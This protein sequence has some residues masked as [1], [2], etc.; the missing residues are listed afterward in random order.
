MNKKPAKK[1][2][3]ILILVYLLILT[4]N[5]FLGT[6]RI[7]KAHEHHF[8][9]GACAYGFLADCESCSTQKCNSYWGFDVNYLYFGLF[10]FTF[11]TGFINVI[12]D[13]SLMESMAVIFLAGVFYLVVTEII[14][15]LFG[16]AV[17]YT[18][19]MELRQSLVASA[20]LAV[21]PEFNLMPLLFS[22]ITGFGGNALG[23]PLLFLKRKKQ[24][25]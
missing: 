1:I 9:G 10:I 19:F 5:F 2:F 17:L 11:I 12:L 25:N 6:Q 24:L 3:L 16:I 7:I 14:V 23:F 21:N 4:V 18:N 15:R 8:N 22:Q 13:K 20:F